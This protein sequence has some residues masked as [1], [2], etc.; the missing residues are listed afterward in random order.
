MYV[1]TTAQDAVPLSSQVHDR[2]RS[3]ILHAHLRPGTLLSEN[4]LA[5]RMGVSRTPVREAIQRLARE[6]L[7]RV[8]PQRG[9]QVALLSMQRVREA[10]FVRE[11]VECNVI[12]RLLSTPLDGAAL[13]SL[14][15]CIQRQAAAMVAQ[16][17]E[18]MMRCDEDFHHRL[19]S[20][21]R[22]EGIWPMVAQARD[23]HQ[24]VRAI[25]VPELQSGGQAVAD[26]RAILHALRQHDVKLATH[27]MAR[28]LHQNEI[29][30]A[31]IA[32]LHPDYFLSEA[33][34]AP[35][36]GAPAAERQLSVRA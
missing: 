1:L 21:C 11:A 10:L 29:L 9:S 3:E 36:D 27:E 35:T 24:R 19:L 16:D 6:G 26:H 34:V 14:E 28:H 30:T 13:D 25:A 18:A 23:M 5:Q 32:A 8:L 4:L 22:M 20:L 33:V 17:L 15:S 12:R 7:V 31:Q 2:L